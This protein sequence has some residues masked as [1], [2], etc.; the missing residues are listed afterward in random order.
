EDLS[1]KKDPN[2]IDGNEIFY[3]WLK[4]DLSQALRIAEKYHIKVILENTGS[5]SDQQEVIKRVQK[6]LNIPLVDIYGLMKNA[7]DREKFIHPYLVSRLS[8]EGNLFIAE[9][10]CKTLQSSGI[11]D[12]IKH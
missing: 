9:E 2:K 10:I 12:K 6:E 1:G 5:S 3:R 4:Y 11:L 8:K 7:P